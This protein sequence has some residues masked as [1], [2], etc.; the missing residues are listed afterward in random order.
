MKSRLKKIIMILVI[1]NIGAIMLLSC[2]RNKI[3][4]A[5]EE[6]AGK[7]INYESLLGT[8]I[9]NEDIAS[10]DYPEEYISF[11]EGCEGSGD[12][13][14]FFWNIERDGRL[15]IIVTDSLG[16]THSF[17][18]AITI[19]GNELKLD[20]YSYT[21]IEVGNDDLGQS[22]DS[23]DNKLTYSV[24]QNMGNAD[25]PDIS[26]YVGTWYELGH[27]DSVHGDEY[28]TIYEDSTFIDSDGFAGSV[29]ILE[30]G[31]KLT[32]GG[33]GVYIYFAQYDGLD[34]LS[35]DER[36]LEDCKNEDYWDNRW[37][38]MYVKNIDDAR[39]VKKKCKI[40]FQ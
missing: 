32:C 15:H 27:L 37:S 19:N 28:I 34:V 17:D 13:N 18:Y 33:L 22:S 36:Y 6:I 30:N 35:E 5:N 7:D 21:R 16:D 3:Q 25:E 26:K 39:E 10:S 40:A 8:Y 12:G 38:D 4:S 31:L 20:E 2:E 14:N 23:E 29:T 9:P 24:S 11:G 1:L